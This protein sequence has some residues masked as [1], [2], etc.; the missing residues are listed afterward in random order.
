MSDI[1]FHLDVWRPLKAHRRISF[2]I[3]DRDG[4]ARQTDI[5]QSDRLYEQVYSW[6]LKGDPWVALGDD[7]V[8]KN[9]QEE[10]TTGFDFNEPPE[11]RSFEKLSSIVEKIGK[12]LEDD[13]NRP[14]QYWIQPDNENDS[15]GSFQLQPILALYH[16]LKWLCELFEDLPGASVTIR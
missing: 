11:K 8:C 12:Y 13:N 7:E 4:N 16:H 3:E 1:Q 14:W 9:I 15:D 6:N 5:T 2:G 10:L